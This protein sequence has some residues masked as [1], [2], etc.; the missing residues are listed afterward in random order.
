[1]FS[2]EQEMILGEL[3]LQKLAREFRLIKDPALQKYVD[4]LGAR[5]IAHLPETGLRFT[6]HIIDYPEANAF[7]IPGGHVFLSRK[8]ITLAKNEDELAGVIGHELGHA[9]VHHGAIDMSF[10]MRK[11]LSIKSV[12]DRKDIIEK[13]NLLIENQR[14]KW[15]SARRGHGDDQ[16]L[17][18][19]RIGLF[20]M[21]S[22]GYDP[23]AVFTFFERLTETDSKFGSWFSRIFGGSST[24]VKVRLAEMLQLT[25]ELPPQCRDSKKSNAKE[26]FARWQTD[27]VMYRETGRREELPGL[28]WKR[29]LQPKLRSDINHFAFSTSGKLLLAQDDFGITVISVPDRRVLLQMPVED[30]REAKFTPDDKYVV[31]TT[32]NLRFERWDIAAG[33][34]VE[35]RE[36]VV[37]GDCDEHE[38]SPDGKYIACVTS[39]GGARLID[40]KTGDRVW[41]KK[42]FY[43]FNYQL[44]FFFSSGNFG[45]DD[46]EEDPDPDLVTGFFRIEFSPDSRYAIFSRSRKNDYLLYGPALIY[47]QAS[48]TALA[49]DTSTMQPVKLDGELKKIAARPYVF[50]DSQRILGMSSN[51]S[52]D[53]GVFSF[54]DGKR[55]QKFVLFGRKVIRTQN[56]NYIFLKPLMKTRLGLF[57]VKTGTLLTGMNKAS[58]TVSGDLIAFESASGKI[59]IKR[60]TDQAPGKEFQSEDV[61][62]IDLPANTIGNLRTANISNNFEWLVISS[63]NRGGLWNV[64]SGERKAFLRGFKGSIVNEEGFSVGDF[65]KIHDADQGLSLI[66]PKSGEAGPFREMP[67]KGGR[68]YGRFLLVRKSLDEKAGREK[69]DKKP[70]R[71]DTEPA[72]NPRDLRRNVRFEIKDVVSDKVLWTKDFLKEAPGYSFDGYPGRLLLF[73]RLSTESGKARLKELPG[74]AA[75]ASALGNKDQDVLLEVVDAYSQKTRGTLLLETGKGS[76]SVGSGMSEADWV[77]LYDNERRVLI[78][79]LKDGALKHRFFGENAAIDPSRNLVAVENFPGEVNLYDLDSGESRARVVFNGKA[80]F[81]RFNLEGDKLF[82]LSDAQSAYAFDLNK[83]LTAVDKPVF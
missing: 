3:T 54:P 40:T 74:M 34:A 41:E 55:L 14:T 69:D 59:V 52:E 26:D 43:E 62:T 68:Q 25:K 63:K 72:E 19:D 78:Y 75:Q 46:R 13:Y 10:S 53:S 67:E 64:A 70:V 4:D 12:G 6:F 8:L 83:A 79:S 16:Q 9:T 22:A 35:A 5:I 28:L 32:S 73:W 20:A 81:V 11:I 66:D 30:A 82:I 51:D 77:L 61:A 17:E 2:P 15:I 49:L 33:K 37:R 71:T 36:V 42:N 24:P 23:D 31:L 27:V 38:L 65:P 48:S 29:E 1:M 21:A 76:F 45:E 80:A 60:I 18:A 39:M 50:L 57:D 47:E 56:P 7:N 44:T 58:A